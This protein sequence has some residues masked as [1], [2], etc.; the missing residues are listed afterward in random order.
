[1]PQIAAL[2]LL[3]ELLERVFSLREGAGGGE[4]GGAEAEAAEEKAAIYVLVSGLSCVPNHAA[5]DLPRHT[6]RLN[7]SA[8]P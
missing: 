5:R 4:R 7:V 3:D 1:M 2:V 8:A 6:A